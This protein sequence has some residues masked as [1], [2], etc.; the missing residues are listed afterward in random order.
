MSK[1]YLIYAMQGEKMCFLHALM[2]AKQLKAKGHEVKIVLEGAA[3]KLIPVL[4]NEKNP[5]YFGLKEDKTIAG[6]CLACSKVLG[7]YE[8]NVASG[9]PMLNDM[10]GHAGIAP[11]VEEGY[12]TLIF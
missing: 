3:C 9:I 2:N 11:Y 10:M 12:E 5:L 8:A 6:V 1:K 7:V 4:E